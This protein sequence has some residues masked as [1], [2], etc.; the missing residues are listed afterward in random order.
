MPEAVSNAEAKDWCE[1][2]RKL[3]SIS[4]R[5]FETSREAGFRASYKSIDESLVAYEEARYVPSIVFEEMRAQHLVL[6]GKAK[7]I[8]DSNKVPVEK[9]SLMVAL[10]VEQA[11]LATKLQSF[12]ADAKA[13]A[14]AMVPYKE[15]LKEAQGKERELRMLNLANASYET[16]LTNL[17]SK[18]KGLA[19]NGEIVRAAQEM[20]LALPLFTKQQKLATAKRKEDLAIAR[21]KP[22]FDDKVARLRAAIAQLEPM[23]G[24]GAARK[25]LQDLINEGSAEASRSSDFNSAYGALKGLTEN[26]A[27]GL[28]AA[29]DF[30][31]N[32]GNP[33]LRAL[34]S[35]TQQ[36]LAQYTNLAGLSHPERVTAQSAALQKAV[37]DLA[38]PTPVDK[39]NTATAALTAIGTNLVQWINDSTAF[40]SQYDKLIGEARGLINTT[41]DIACAPIYA[42]HLSKFRL[43]ETTYGL[44]D[45]SAAFQAL[46]DGMTAARKLKS[47]IGDAREQWLALTATVDKDHLPTLENFRS[48]NITIEPA[49]TNASNLRSNY[50]N[51]RLSVLNSRNYE[52]AFAVAHAV[53]AG[54]PVIQK[55]YDEFIAAT[56]QR[57]KDSA[58]LDTAKSEFNAV[59]KNLLLQGAD[60]SAFRSTAEAAWIDYGLAVRATA[61]R[62]E[63]TAALGIAL[64][65]T[66][67]VLDEVKT[68]MGTPALFDAARTA[69]A[70]TLLRAQL[71]PLLTRAKAQLAD[72]SA[73]YPTDA[74][75]LNLKLDALVQQAN[76]N[77]TQSTISECEALLKQTGELKASKDSG[78]TV[79]RNQAQAGV[80]RSVKLVAKLAK[81]N[82]TFKD[83]FAGLQA[84]VL[85]CAA[86]AGS[87]VLKVVNSANQRLSAGGDVFE[88]LTAMGASKAFGAVDKLLKELRA[89]LDGNQDL[90]TC[91]PS[92]RDSLALRLSEQV[93]SDCYRSTPELAE[94]TLTGFKKVVETAAA[95]ASRAA[96]ARV[97]I[98]RKRDEATNLLNQRD[99]PPLHAL[100]VA[101]IEQAATPAEGSESDCINK[102][103]VVIEML[104][105]FAAGGPQVDAQQDQMALQFQA[106]A[107]AQEKAGIEWV[108]R[109]DLFEKNELRKAKT[110]YDENSKTHDETRMKA[111]K[112]LLEE[113]KELALKGV[114]TQAV[115]KLEEAIAM[116][117]AFI[118]SP[119]NAT[120]MARNSLQ[121]VAVKWKGVVAAF[122]T[123]INALATEIDAAGAAD[124]SAD[125]ASV[126]QAT[127]AV[128]GLT[129]SFDPQMFDTVVDAMVAPKVL[130][131]QLRKFKE[132]ALNSVRRYQAVV[133]NDPL[134]HHMEAGNPF[135]Q[136]SLKP[137]RDALADLELNFKRA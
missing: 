44:Q 39:V 22:M 126:T 24:T 80:D 108:V 59:M 79:V 133:A 111:I 61:D 32:V 11:T 53:V 35:R 21:H 34:L 19:D 131:P 67:A 116:A 123:R 128:R 136:V 18:A 104:T 68:V 99:F 88:T 33:P 27:S 51:V 65:S 109:L 38:I 4:N 117:K 71:K 15:S 135:R 100:F 3:L 29:N 57:E 87:S 41:K 8:T 47:E 6:A 36:Q 94:Q 42:V 7:D 31:K 127:T 112:R 58:A 74:V 96:Q 55:A 114:K 37:Y 86:M 98:K 2:A 56:A 92:I 40:K 49:S 84:D 118:A 9:K 81:D 23:P 97:D 124:P 1:K 134:L 137:L 90:K 75:L 83:Y 76:A 78:F 16:P 77:V 89:I 72:L 119:H 12:V 102:L 30:S 69:Q 66:Q 120:T 63:L 95:T 132:D 13:N 60:D 20:K 91:T 115:L 73:E 103:D 14:A 93:L 64:R 85:D 54:M 125:V 129:M 45:Y 105:R 122:A 5:V 28:K 26:L 46:E 82:P 106:N 121:A 101:R 43:T 70:Q 10:A 17:I 48:K 130:M 110:A 62:A 50:S 107:F 52:G 113:A 25:A